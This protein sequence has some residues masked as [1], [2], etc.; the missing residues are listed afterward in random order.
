[1]SKIRTQRR[2]SKIE[3]FEQGYASKCIAH[4]I[5]DNLILN[6]NNECPCGSVVKK[7]NLK[8]HLISKKH[9]KFEEKE[10]EQ[11]DECGICFTDQ[12]EFFTCS[13]C[14]NKHCLSCHEQLINPFCPY[15]REPNQEEKEEE[16]EEEWDMIF[17]RQE[18]LDARNFFGY[19]PV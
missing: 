18:F 13:I 9:K 1:M 12:S 15:C 11:K 16:K 2:S 17:D 5:M 8:R 3:K 19:F 6:Q 7:T 14:K 4:R 10:V